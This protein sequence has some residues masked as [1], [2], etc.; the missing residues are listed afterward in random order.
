MFSSIRKRISYANV[1]M[2]FALVFAMT[3]GAYA[4]GK[5]LVTSTKQISPKVLSAL[6]GKTGSVGPAGPTGPVGPIGATGPTGPKGDTGLAGE[7]G[8]QGETG[9]EGKS[10]TSVTSAVEP[11]GANCAEGGSKFMAANGTTYACNGAEGKAGQQGQPGEPWTVGGKL[12]SGKTE[13]GSWND[14]GDSQEGKRV[15]VSISFTLPVEDSEEK[16]PEGEFVYAN[17]KTAPTHCTGSAA[18]PTAPAGFLCV[19]DAYEEEVEGTP[20]THVKELVFSDPEV[21]LGTGVGKK[22][23]LVQLETVKPSSGG[24]PFT[25]AWG[26][27]AVTAK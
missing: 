19:Y 5:Y 6:K 10:G 17:P 20:T 14:F 9:K 16:A 22:G 15:A 24:F 7:T 8:K 12:P 3:G 27:W 18:A 4:A 23:A 25:I 26:T 1:A 13:Y 2:T 21:A 11:K